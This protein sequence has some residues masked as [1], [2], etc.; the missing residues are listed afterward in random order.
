MV[1]KK[2]KLEENDYYNLVDGLTYIMLTL[3]YLNIKLNLHT[4]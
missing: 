4:T 1:A 3:E 2:R